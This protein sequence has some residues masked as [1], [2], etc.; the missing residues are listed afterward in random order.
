[1]ID[2]HSQHQ[3][4]I[5]SDEVFRISA[6]D[7]L[8][9][10]KSLLHRYLGEY[11]NLQ[12]LRSELR[13]AEEVAASARRDQEWITHQVEELTAANLRL[14]ESEE[15][16]AELKILENAEHI[17]QAF[18][19]FRA[20]MESDD[21]MGILVALRSSQKEMQHIAKSYPDAVDYAERLGG[22]LAELKDMYST[23]SADSE[24]IE[25]DPERLAKLSGRIDMIYSLCQKHHVTDLAELIDIRDKYTSQLGAILCSDE[26]I[27]KLKGLID[28]CESRAKE[29]AA[30]ISERR[31]KAAPVFQKNI[32]KTLNKLGMEQAKFIV[33]IAQTKQLTTSGWDQVDFLFSSVEGKTPQA[34]EKIASGGEVSRVML[35]LKALL[36][37]KMSLPTIIFDEI[38]TG[39]SGRI[40]DAMGEIIE[41]LSQQMQVVDITHLPQVAS[42]GES[43][44]VVYKESGHTNITRLTADERVQ[45]IATMISGSIVTDAAVEQAKFLLNR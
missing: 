14:G 45:Q 13:R 20:R 4:Q 11:N 43:H 34:V 9:D 29:L 7:L 30:K 36:A 15:A 42:K 22:V 2:I 6:L 17:S 26:E 19:A 1:M 35:A 18:E 31:A 24:S 41:S 5:L 28:G 16:E 39:V 27:A 40:A 3:N 21:E 44:F 8:Y 23:I 37:Q 33:R 12:S 38:D 32:C 25:A 10:S